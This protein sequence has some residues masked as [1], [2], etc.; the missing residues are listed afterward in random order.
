MLEA[1]GTAA[2]STPFRFM[3]MSGTA[4][5]RDQTKTPSFMAQYSKMRGETENRLLAF[6]AQHKDAMEVCVAKPGLIT[7]K[8][9]YLKTVGAMALNIIGLVPNLDIREVSAAMLQQV[10]DGWEK[11]PLEHVDLVRIGR[12]VLN[13]AATS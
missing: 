4:A 13:D 2:A 6:A 3:Y 5:E 9:Q 7:A 12:Q 10:L 1:R 8:G 11:E